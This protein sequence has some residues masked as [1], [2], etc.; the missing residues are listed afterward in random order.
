VADAGRRGAAAQSSRLERIHA[1]GV[2]AVPK[3]KPVMTRP[4]R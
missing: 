2:E 4:V 1:I 3:M